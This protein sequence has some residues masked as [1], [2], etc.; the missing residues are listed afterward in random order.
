MLKIFL[1]Q[2]LQHKYSNFSTQKKLSQT[3]EHQRIYFNIYRRDGVLLPG[4][5]KVQK[6]NLTNPIFNCCKQSLIRLYHPSFHLITHP[7]SVMFLCKK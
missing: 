4:G 2:T 5:Q 1:L 7:S 3:C 6:T